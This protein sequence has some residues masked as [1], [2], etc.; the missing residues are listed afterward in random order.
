MIE[1]I[2]WDND[3]VLVD[4]EELY[5][6]ATRE[7]AALE[8]VELTAAQFLRVSLTA[9]LSMLGILLER[10]VPP[11]RVEELRRERNRIYRERLLAGV[12]VPDGVPEALAELAPRYRMGVV[13]SSLREHFDA[14]HT[15]TGL[16]GYF[17]FVLARED[18]RD[19]KPSPEPYLAALERYGLD[20]RQCVAV[21][22]SSRGL[23]SALAAGLRCIVIPAGLTRGSDFTGAA[24]VLASAVELSTAVEAIG[25][26]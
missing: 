6:A 19:S 25:S 12:R 13:T 22:D 8:G 11:E 26:A 1:A 9:G 20:P 4:T 18:Y 16:A 21:E 5:F 24:A 17:E 23:E 3:G 7:A 15:A 14:A 10:G 2:L